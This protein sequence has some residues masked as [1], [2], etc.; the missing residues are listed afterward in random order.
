MSVRVD[1]RSHLELGDL[2]ALL[3]DGLDDLARRRLQRRLHLRMLR[4]YVDENTPFAALH[5][6]G[7]V[8]KPLRPYLQAKRGLPERGIARSGGDRVDECRRRTSTRAR[9][10]IASLGLVEGCGCRSIVPCLDSGAG[11][12]H[13]GTG[14]R[15]QPPAHVDR[16]RHLPLRVR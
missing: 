9:S 14:S 4:L 15:S 6:N 12:R 3:D 11:R 8:A 10:V 2:H 16:I 7:Q 13:A 5:V 1:Q